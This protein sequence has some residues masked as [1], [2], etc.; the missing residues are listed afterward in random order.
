[1]RLYIGYDRIDHSDKGWSLDTKV[2]VY[3]RLG[4][5]NASFYTLFF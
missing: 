1:M 2:R 4:T 3:G 5:P